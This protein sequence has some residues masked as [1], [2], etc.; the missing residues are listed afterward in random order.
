[1]GLPETDNPGNGDFYKIHSG[2]VAMSQGQD[3]YATHERGYIYPPL[4]AALLQPLGSTTVR[5]AQGW[6]AAINFALT[7]CALTLGFLAVSE[8]LRVPRERVSALGA[9]LLAVALAFDQIRWEFEKGQTDTLMLLAFA[10]GLYFLDRFPAAVGAVLGFAANIKFQTLVALPYLLIRRRW[11]AAA[12]MAA[13]CIAWALAPALVCGWDRNLQFLQTDLADV[14]NGLTGDNTGL[15]VHDVRWMSSISLVSAAA[16]QW[17]EDALAATVALLAAGAFGTAWL[18]YRKRGIAMFS[19]RTPAADRQP[20]GPAVVLL[21][22]CGLIVASLAFSPQTMVRHTFLLLL[23]NLTVAAILLAPR[24]GVRRW[25]LAAGVIVMQLGTR[26]PPNASAFLKWRTAWNSIGG[27]SWCAL[28]LFI[29]LLWT[30]LEYV[31]AGAAP[32]SANSDELA[33]AQLAARKAVF[34][35]AKEGTYGRE[36]LR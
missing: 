10:A 32:E 22:W 19:G 9:A 33:G 34:R 31:R 3:I 1:M 5:I 20:P 27:P 36:R 4:F 25:P 15:H 24:A 13:G 12:W 16:R 6:W 7:A 35:S 17:G 26:L 8:R 21:E 2:V 30:G 11:A 29:S 18:V 14:W 23:V 28:A